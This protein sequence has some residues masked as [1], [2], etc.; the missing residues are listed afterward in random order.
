MM[1]ADFFDD[2]YP[3]YERLRADPEPLRVEHRQGSYQRDFILFSRYADAR[4]VFAERNAISKDSGANRP[5]GEPPTPLDMHMLHRDGEEHQRL[6]RL[7]AGYFSP[8]AMRG[9]TAITMEVVGAALDSMREWDRV[10]LVKDFAEPIPLRIIASVMGVPVAD[11]PRVRAWTLTLSAGFDS[12]VSVEQDP[13]LLTA[14]AEEFFS[15]LNTL[16]DSDHRQGRKTLIAHLASARA[17]GTI[18]AGEAVGMAMFLLVAGHETTVS[19]IGSGLW[20]L[21]SHPDQLALLR[22]DP[23]LIDSAVEEILRYESPLQRT[24][25]RVATTPMTLGS[26]RLEAGQQFGVIMGAANRDESEFPAANRFDIQRSPNRHLAF[27]G[28]LHDCL[29]KHL[30]RLEAKMALG[31][32]F[33]RYPRLELLSDRPVWRRNSFFRGL[34]RLPVQLGR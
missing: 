15:Y 25:F 29:G 12:F 2:P 3:V 20:L 22:Q 1:D 11:L 18:S 28:G 23:R 27:G 6:R 5:V 16:I 7:V 10:D 13:R 24:T 8:S 9:L 17:S 21:L 14:C 31:M 19:L 33:S 32:I 30:A 4:K 34:Q 26:Y